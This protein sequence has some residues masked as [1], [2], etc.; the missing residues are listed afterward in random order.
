MKYSKQG[1]V[2]NFILWSDENQ[3]IYSTN[4]KLYRPK[5]FSGLFMSSDATLK[6]EGYIDCVARVFKAAQDACESSIGCNLLCFISGPECEGCM[7][8][9][10]AVACVIY[11]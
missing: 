9:A 2:E 8:A 5:D 3:F 10:A 7:L 4:D 6:G 11:K 1:V